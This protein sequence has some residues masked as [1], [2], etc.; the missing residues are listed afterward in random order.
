MEEE[1]LEQDLIFEGKEMDEGKKEQGEENKQR[2][3]EREDF[4][5]STPTS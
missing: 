4:F 3:W 5:H 2:K 1:I